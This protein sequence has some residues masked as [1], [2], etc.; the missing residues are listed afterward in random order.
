[1]DT[2]IQQWRDA[3]QESLSST[4]FTELIVPY[5]QIAHAFPTAQFHLRTFDHKMIDDVA[6][7]EWCKERGWRVQLAPELLPQESELPPPVLFKRID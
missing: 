6:L 7:K 4:K 2:E 1:M 5:E 3:L